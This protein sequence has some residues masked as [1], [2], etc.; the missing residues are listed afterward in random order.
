MTA[1][2]PTLYVPHGAGPCFFMRWDP[3]DTWTRMGDW[4]RGALADLPRRPTAIVVVSSHWEAPRFTVQ[5]GER[6]ALL[7]DYG[8]FPPH[9]YDL[10][11]PAAG[12]PTLAARVGALL[13]GEGLGHDVDPARAWDHGVFVPLLLMAPNADIPVVQV[14]LA[15]G[16]DVATH[17]AAGRALAPLR[18]DG[19]LIVGS[20]MSYHNMRGYR[21]PEARPVSD[22]FDAW[23]TDAVAIEA[24]GLR[25]DRLAT[26]AEHPDGRA[27]HPR[28]EH[29]APLFVVAGAG[30]SAPGRRVFSD[31]VMEAT[32]SAFR[33]D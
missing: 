5:T 29:L 17:V 27:A 9:T 23:L 25:A 13:D 20:G 11:Y 2:M 22:R 1:R 14:S 3:P 30:G 19:V 18:D 26:W 6:P 12:S 7:F 33:F 15:Q 10:R 16:L 24:P 21:R 8:G 28:A 31:R 32:V 4:L